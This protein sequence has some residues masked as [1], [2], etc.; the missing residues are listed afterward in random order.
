MASDILCFAFLTRSL[1]TTSSFLRR[2]Y[3]GRSPH[4]SRASTFDPEPFWSCNT[5]THLCLLI[6]VEP[7]RQPHPCL[8][9]ARKRMSWVRE[10]G[11]ASLYLLTP[12]LTQSSMVQAGARRFQTQGGFE[13]LT[14]TSGHRPGC[15]I[16]ISNPQP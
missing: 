2:P 12:S 8:S 16:L 5:L 13:S 15:E 6:T 14:N 3:T 4:D 9:F 10:W 11:G 1:H 7:S